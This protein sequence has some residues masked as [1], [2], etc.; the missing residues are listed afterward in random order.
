LPYDN[1]QALELEAQDAGGA[2]AARRA[3]DAAAFD[4]RERQARLAAGK[5]LTRLPRH[6]D[7]EGVQLGAGRSQAQQALPR[8]EGVIKRD[9]GG[10]VMVLLMGDAP[11]GSAYVA[12]QSFVR[13]GGDGKVVELRT[14]YGDGAASGG[15]G[16]AVLAALKRRCG[17]PAE[18][19]ATWARV[20]D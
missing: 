19:P 12:R 18:L 9:R 17:A 3:A 7:Y 6:L 10:G 1:S 8:G 11:R 14:R 13:F 20:W 2:D 15:C 5:P 4:R 16:Q